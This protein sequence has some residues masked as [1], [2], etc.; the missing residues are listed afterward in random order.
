MFRALDTSQVIVLILAAIACW[1][2]LR[3]RHIPNLLTFG[4]AALALIYSLFSHGAAGLF[5][6]LGGWLTGVALFLPFFLLGGMGAGD[7]KLI[8]CIGAWLGPEAA[9]WVALYSM[10][11]GGVMALAL[12]LAT[13]YLGEALLN[14]FMLLGHW[15]KAGLKP[16]P[17][18]TLAGTSRGPRLPYALPIAAGTLAVFWLR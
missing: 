5:I 3:T 12:A 6:S 15:R 17:A 10:I 11:A 18:L 9:F 1:F 4:G 13:G 2:D 7:V 14:V 8:G 16:L